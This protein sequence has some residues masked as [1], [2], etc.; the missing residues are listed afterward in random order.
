[1]EQGRLAGASRAAGPHDTR[2]VARPVRETVVVRHRDRLHPPVLP[3][4]GV[5][6]AFALVGLVPALEPIRT[7]GPGLLRVLSDRHAVPVLSLIHISE[8]TR[9]GMISYAVFC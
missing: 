2:L 8:P 7:V 3:G 9:L 6:C 1:M 5:R 4:A